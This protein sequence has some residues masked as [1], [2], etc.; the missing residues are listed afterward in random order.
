M[1][2]AYYFIKNCQYQFIAS[3]DIKDEI[4][5][6]NPKN[7]E[8]PVIRISKSRIS[9]VFFDK[10][11]IL[12][13]HDTVKHLFRCT[14]DLLDIHLSDEVIE[15]QEDQIDMV[16][17]GPDQCSD[18]HLMSIF[19]GLGTVVS[20]IEDPK[21][22]MEK[23]SRKLSE[24]QKE[25]I[26]QNRKTALQPP[27]A[28]MVIMAICIVVFI[29]SLVLSLVFK[30]LA[31]P[32][33]LSV[34]VS[35]VLGSYYKA[36]VVGA[37]EYWRFF[38]SAFV[39]TD[40]IHLLMNMM[41]LYNMGMLCEKFMGTRDFLITLFGSILFGSAFVYL[42]SGNVVAMGIS[43]GLYGLLAAFLVYG[44][45]TRILFQPQLR[46]QFLLIIMINIMISLMPG[47]SLAAHAGGFVGGL[48]ISLILT[49]ND[50]WKQLRKNTVVALCVAV[51]F[52]GMKI[53]EPQSRELDAI[54]GG[55][56]QMVV[57]MLSDMHLDSY[58]DHLAKQMAELYFKEKM[59]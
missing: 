13:I 34:A 43:G 49:K 39:H 44:I 41:A 28:T 3:K 1:Q 18:Q 12:Q 48:L 27:K 56:D 23:I 20:R 19:P 30:G 33:E 40:F 8:Y 42:G 10:S 11:R 35:I 21:A 50:S 5:L 45:Q 7:K 37:H 36:F 17:M 2:L 6:G 4:W 9:S 38:T 24:L 55:T 57:E 22:E 59:Q 53:A 15:E 58:G 52:L 29:L 47:V 51:I 25:K 46:T 14:G 16:T 32:N 54:Y 31:N 26:K